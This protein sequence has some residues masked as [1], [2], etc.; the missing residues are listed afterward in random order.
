MNKNAIIKALGL[1][2]INGAGVGVVVNQE[3]P[4]KVS[5]PLDD[6]VYSRG[7]FGWP[8]SDIDVMNMTNNMEVKNALERRNIKRPA[9]NGTKDDDVALDTVVMNGES[10]ES[11]ADRM[12][13]F[14]DEYESEVN[15]NE[16]E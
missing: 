3:V 7:R 13:E 1:C 2:L 12:A 6:I 10:A 8:E 5:S 4:K 14:M 11:Y 9:P 15:D 16:S